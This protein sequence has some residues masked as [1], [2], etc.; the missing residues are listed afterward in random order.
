[1]GIIP[2]LLLVGFRCR[3]AAIR[4]RAIHLLVSISSHRE[5]IWDASVAT[6]VVKDV[7]EMEEQS[8]RSFSSHE[9]AAE[10]ASQM[11]PNP[12][13]PASDIPIEERV[14]TMTPILYDEDNMR[15]EIV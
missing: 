6:E 11:A 4:R 8:A 14:K 13:G 3:H 12:P 5:V 1:M 15:V 2:A 7:M 9:D 10:S